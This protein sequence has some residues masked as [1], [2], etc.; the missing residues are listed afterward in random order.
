MLGKESALTPQFTVPA[1]DYNFCISVGGTPD[2]GYDV[3][4]HGYHDGFP[5]YEI[6]I[7]LPDCRWVRVY[8]HDPRVTGDYVW[9]LLGTADVKVPPTV[10]HV[11][12]PPKR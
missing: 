7:Q 1:I 3:R 12:L 6:W 9:S 11:H 10:I 2:G 5:A 8:G 4:I